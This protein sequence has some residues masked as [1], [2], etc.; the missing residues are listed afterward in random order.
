MA[1][2]ARLSDGLWGLL[3]CI[4]LHTAD[5]APPSARLP[6]SVDA[7]LSSLARLEAL[8]NVEQHKT[9]AEAES[10]PEGVALTDGCRIAYS[11]VLVA[12]SPEEA[13]ALLARIFTQALTNNPRL[14]V[15]GV[16]FYDETT[17]ALVQVLEGPAS[18]VHTL[19]H[20]KIKPDP[21]H[22]S[23][24]LLWDTQIDAR[25]YEGFGMQLGSDPSYVLS[26][27]ED[28]LQL[29]YVSQLTAASTLEASQ[30]LEQILGVAIVNNPRLGIG[31]ALF[32]NPRT[33]QVVQTL[34][35][36]E[37]HVRPLYEKIAKDRRHTDCKILSEVRAK[38]RTYEQW[39][40]LQGD[41]QDWSALAVGQASA[42][43]TPALKRRRRAR[44]DMEAE[45][46]E[47]T[48]MGPIRGTAKDAGEGGDGEGA[49]PIHGDLKMSPDG[50]RVTVALAA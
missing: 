2:L 39:G 3:G 30:H 47:K 16:L 32:L 23:V 44:E 1:D 42:S 17:S 31:G 27:K 37:A 20:E 22:D 49:K 6:P 21:R 11:S 36:V 48:R 15:G 34:E 28:V 25:M 43:V 13:Q 5:A 26:S 29:T 7:R 10:A 38:E 35:G 33:L 46:G 19:F 40:M 45:D 8:A 4:G 9:S 24:K 18:A 50:P 12:K 14:E 41:L